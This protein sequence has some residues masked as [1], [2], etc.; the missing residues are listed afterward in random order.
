MN[1]TLWVLSDNARARAF[2]CAIGFVHEP[3]QVR[4]RDRGGVSLAEIRLRRRMTDTV[5]GGQETVSVVSVF[6]NASEAVEL[7]QELDAD[8]GRRYPG[9]RIHGLRPDESRDPRLVFLV[10]FARGGPIACAALRELEPE[11]GEVKR[12]FVRPGWRGRGVARRLLAE[13]ESRAAGRGLLRMR[14]ETGRQ[15]PEAI[16][17]Y[18]IGRL[19]A[20]PAVR[21]I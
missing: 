9:A 14:L 12:M 15:Q 7:M 16:A 18:R 20:D 11:V 21:R 10:A 3:G 5:S 17:L 1:V 6:A 2:Y 8:L 4:T 19:C 13:L